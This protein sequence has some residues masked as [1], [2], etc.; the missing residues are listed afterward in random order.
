MIKISRFISGNTDVLSAQ[1]FIFE[2]DS[3][4]LL[5]TVYAE[6]DN[7]FTQIRQVV[8]DLEDDFFD[9]EEAIALR[10]ENLLDN[11]KEKLKNLEEVQ[12]L[13]ACLQEHAKVQ[14]SVSATLYLLSL[15]TTQAY[16]LRGDNL[17]TLLANVKET[18]MSGHLQDNDKLIFFAKSPS[19]VLPG[20]KAQ[21][22]LISDQEEL[23][24][25][26][27][28]E[29]RQEYQEPFSFIRVDFAGEKLAS[30]EKTQLP[31]AIESIMNKLSLKLFAKFTGR[32]AKI[33]LIA[34]LA[35]A[36]IGFVGYYFQSKRAHQKQAQVEE[37]LKDARLDFYRAQGVKDTD[38]KEAQESFAKAE[39]KL[40]KASKILPKDQRVQTL[41]NQ[42]SQSKEEILKVYEVSQ[43]HTFL[44]LDLIK[45]NF[46]ANKMF[47]Y[48]GKL[49]LIDQSSQSP[50]TSKNTTVLID[51]ESKTN[52]ILAGFDQVGDVSSGSLNGDLAFVFSPDKG[53]SSIDSGT[54]KIT[55]VIKPDSSWGRIADLYVFAGNIY[56][57][58]SLQNQIW[59]YLP[60]A[61]GYSDKQ[62]YFEGGNT[63]IAGSKRMH[64]DSSIWVLEDGKI[65]KFTSGV[66]D[67]FFPNISDKPLGE[68]AAFYLSDR[69][70]NIYILDKGNLRIVILSKKGD[71][72]GQYYSDKFKD[73]KDIAVSESAKKVYLLN[74]QQIL[75]FDLK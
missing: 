6:G 45:P 41:K 20:E 27:E 55:N 58:D 24:F 73:I 57:L 70:D 51:I 13:T 59:K 28:S 26:S 62:E 39:D 48:L 66:I 16:L 65:K 30:D 64:I 4:R 1:A 49:I 29:I 75:T 68:V 60:I 22:L 25:F 47:F 35:L 38:P 42:I 12:I 54:R 40:K 63:E 53:V 74:S 44:S 67:S 10:L 36:L 50:T 18:L 5:V 71:Y 32:R 15:G 17:V 3:L 56:L 52:Q 43:L 11:L 8:T 69:T 21:R 72:Q 33:V 34:V 14:E 37:L 31:G 23:E 61:S 46:S 2:R 19:Y 9:Q 7:A